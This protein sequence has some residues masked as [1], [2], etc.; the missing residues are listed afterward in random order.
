MK[1]LNTPIVYLEDQDFSS[2]GRLIADL[3]KDK[4]VVVMIQ[5]TWCGYCTGSKPDFQ[6]FA[7]SHKGEVICATIQ[8][9]GETEGEKK[10][11]ERIS[12]LVPNFRGFPE[13]A[14]YQNGK[15]QQKELKD[16]SVNGLKEFANLR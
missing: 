4:P 7:D 2:D 13:Y 11:S 12:K 9:D 1:Y 5:S 6:K 3:P 10:L 16:R 8:A 14:L 15:Y